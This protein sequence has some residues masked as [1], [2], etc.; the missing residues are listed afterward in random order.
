MV[1][2]Q[3]TNT[4]G[5]GQ[6]TWIVDLHEWKGGANLFAGDSIICPPGEVDRVPQHNS[7]NQRCEVEHGREL[8]RTPQMGSKLLC[9]RQHSLMV[10]KG[11]R[12]S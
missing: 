1:L 2:V 8:K 6:Q 4:R 5:R 12:E 9:W 10:V 11:R 3:Y 7:G